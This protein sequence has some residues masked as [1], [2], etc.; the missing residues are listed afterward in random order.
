M[1]RSGGGFITFE[2]GEGAGKTTQLRRLVSALEAA[3]E[4]VVA[5][6]EPG[7]A[8][9]A[10]DIRRLL[11]SGAPGRWDV[12]SEA[13]LMVAARRDHAESL[14]RPT[15][16]RG[17]WVVCDRFADSTMAYQGLAGGLGREAVDRLHRLAIPDLVPD[18][19]L[20]FDL[21][22]A[23]GLAR[24]QAR[25]GPKGAATEDR[26]EAKGL[27]FHRRLRDAFLSIAADH[28]DRVVVIDASQHEAAVAGAVFAAVSRRFTDLPRLTADDRPTGK[29]G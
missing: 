19:T 14:I 7:G 28:P 16:A 26:F 12:V 20:L 29:A 3:G 25:L 22:P 18:L 5:T 10:E 27:D 1:T 4:A 2:G 6:R 9:G 24:A 15:L 23:V 11:V 8:A 21:D 13:L 17:A